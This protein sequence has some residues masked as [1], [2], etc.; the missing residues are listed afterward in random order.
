MNFKDD[1]AD[2]LSEHQIDEHLI[3]DLA[4]TATAH[5]AACEL[6]ESRVANAAAPIEAFKAVTVAW[7]E[8]R[9]ATLPLHQAMARSAKFHP[10]LAWAAAVT[11][12]LAIGAAIPVVMHQHGQETARIQAASPAPGQI[13]AQDA[14]PGSGSNNIA[15]DNQMLQAIARELNAAVESPEVLGLR[16]ISGTAA[17]KPAHPSSVQD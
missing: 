1:V 11:V 9:S 3:G 10:R 4:G 13:A 6:C 17:R 14:D 12:A 16:P 8:R 5:L 2:H 7:S 15:R